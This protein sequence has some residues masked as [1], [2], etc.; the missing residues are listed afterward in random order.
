M[1]EILLILIG[2]PC[3]AFCFGLL[4]DWRAPKRVAWQW[5]RQTDFKAWQ[6]AQ[7][8]KWFRKI[9]APV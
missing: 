7:E 9:G 4:H 2:A 6:K 3:M 8:E 5:Q 1:I